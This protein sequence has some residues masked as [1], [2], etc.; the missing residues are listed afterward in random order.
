M[1][2]SAPLFYV[3]VGVMAIA[4]VAF[5][6]GCCFCTESEQN[7]IQKSY[8][9]EPLVSVDPIVVNN[10][11]IIYKEQNRTP[12]LQPLEKI[13]ENGPIIVDAN[14]GP[15]PNNVSFT[16]AEFPSVTPMINNVVS[17]NQPLTETV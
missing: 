10:N 8:I 12:L 11:N 13:P 4:F 16:S 2:I 5:I 17:S 7:E 3:I 15:L 1:S 6:V 9:S 14:I